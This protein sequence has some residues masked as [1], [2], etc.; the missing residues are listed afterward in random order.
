MSEKFA[1]DVNLGDCL[2]LFSKRHLVVALKQ[3]GGNIVIDVVFLESKITW[4]GKATLIV[5]ANSLLDLEGA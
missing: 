2:S 1:K 3:D 4:D 5:D